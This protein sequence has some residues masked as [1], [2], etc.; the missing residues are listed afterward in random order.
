[1]E[2]ISLFPAELWGYQLGTLFC[3]HFYFPLYALF[4]SWLLRKIACNSSYPPSAELSNGMFSSWL[5]SQYLLS[6][7][8]NQWKCCVLLIQYRHW[9]RHYHPRWAEGTPNQ[10][11]KLGC[12]PG[13]WLQRLCPRYGGSPNTH[14]SW[15]QNVYLWHYITTSQNKV[16]LTKMLSSCGSFMFQLTSNQ[17]GHVE[18]TKDMKFTYI[19]LVG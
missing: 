16:Y 18:S 19:I 11:P 5:V 3:K 4:M 10:G 15:R 2:K 1:M 7:I 17:T 6:Y 14:K 12:R 13:N 8:L 9:L